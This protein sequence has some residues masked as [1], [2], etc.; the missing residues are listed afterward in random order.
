[1]TS[2]RA[3]RPPTPME[4]LRAAMI[5]DAG[6]ADRRRLTLLRGLDWS[7]PRQRRMA[8]C[9]R[10]LD[11]WGERIHCHRPGCA[12][13]GEALARRHARRVV[14]PA[15]ETAAKAGARLYHATVVLAPKTD[16][17]DCKGE[18]ARGKRALRDA[19]REAARADP[20]LAGVFA[21]GALEIGLV[22]D[23]EIALLGP[24]KKRTLAEL[25]LALPGDGTPTFGAAIWLPH[26]HFVL[27]VPLGADTGVLRAALVRRFP[28][29]L[30]LR[31]EPL[32]GR[33]RAL[34]RHVK[35]CVTY[36]FKTDMLTAVPKPHR[37][38]WDREEVAEFVQFAQRLSPHRFRGF[39]F[40]LLA[41]RAKASVA[42]P[43][44]LFEG[45]DDSDA[46]RE[47]AVEGDES[48]AE[49]ACAV[50]ERG[51]ALNCAA[52]G[53]AGGRWS[54]NAVPPGRTRRPTGPPQR[55][56]PDGGPPPRRGQRRP[57]GP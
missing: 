22:R 23:A 11:R 34:E 44:S 36:P 18:L 40:A 2:D 46:S 49:T 48:G 53:D 13:C 45:A 10:H 16:I 43:S 24:G 56:G 26:L 41:P 7:D 27:A 6:D 54:P 52:L 32:G 31:L 35:R 5:R 57:Q 39:R 55:R 51:G 50:T 9:G 3:P 15:C 25:G 17:V 14:I 21:H 1:M 29:S 12:R 20:R 19:R 42:S 38:V 30:Q 33:G 8:D 28:A 4:R 37:S 47:E